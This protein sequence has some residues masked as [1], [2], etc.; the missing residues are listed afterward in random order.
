MTRRT[1]VEVGGFASGTYHFVR[2][3]DYD[4]DEEAVGLEAVDAFRTLHGDPSYFGNV[5]ASSESREVEPERSYRAGYWTL[6][7]KYTPTAGYMRASGP[8][9]ASRQRR[10]VRVWVPAREAVT[11]NR[12]LTPGTDRTRDTRGGKRRPPRGWLR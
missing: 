11:Y 8:V 6:V 4:R 12:T 2:L 10:W 3:T 9:R 5:G 7:K 1:T